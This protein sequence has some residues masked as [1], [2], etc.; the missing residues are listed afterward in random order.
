MKQNNMR[1]FRIHIVRYF[2]LSGLCAFRNFIIMAILTLVE[3]DI[4]QCILSD[5]PQDIQRIIL[6]YV[7]SAVIFAICDSYVLYARNLSIEHIANNYKKSI[8]NSILYS[9]KAS[10]SEKYSR[11]DLLSKTELDIGVVRDL[12]SSSFLWPFLSIVSGIAASIWIWNIN[13]RVCIGVYLLCAAASICIFNLTF[14]IKKY[15]QIVLENGGKVTEF[16][17]ENISKSYAL[18]MIDAALWEERRFKTAIKNYQVFR[19]KQSHKEVSVQGVK[20]FAKIVL[21]IGV[22]CYG[23]VLA[24]KGSIQFDNIPVLFNMSL[25]IFAMIVSI[26]D[27]FR[28]IIKSSVAFKRVVQKIEPMQE[29]HGCYIKSIQYINASRVG[30]GY[31]DH[32]VFN[33]LS[34]LWK[35]GKIYALVGESGCGKTTLLRSLMKLNPYD[36]SIV[37][38]S[39]ELDK[40]SGKSVRN[41]IS[42]CGQTVIIFEGSIRYNLTVGNENQISDEYIWNV[43]VKLKLD[44]RINDLPGKLD[45][46]LCEG[47]AVFSGGEKR[48]LTLARAILQDKEVMLLD[49]VF[50]G[51]DICGK[52]EVFDYL[53]QL[54]SN[55]IIVVVTHDPEII[56]RC[57]SITR[58]R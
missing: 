56:S 27:S 46:V 21:T 42:Y 34:F 5:R 19:F 53:I 7:I 16:F 14:Y 6:K 38:G 22:S 23:T 57:D 8:L 28:Q 17:F 58:L 10:Y 20:R 12:L 45:Y 31:G 35:R 40:I 13:R 3:K 49:E 39:V 44:K 1:V 24:R 52:E 26:N 18:R 15:Q 25:L 29:D 50:A 2:F 33:G 41:H 32:N 43:L 51:V 9:E 36:G 37:F 47:G 11:G 54:K 55:R 4:I 48:L 30:A